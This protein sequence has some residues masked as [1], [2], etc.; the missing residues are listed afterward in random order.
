MSE[1][2][3]YLLLAG[4]FSVISLFFNRRL[5]KA[6]ASIVEATAIASLLDSIS[7]FSNLVKEE[8][9]ETRRLSERNHE[10]NERN[11]Q[12]EKKGEKDRSDFQMRENKLVEKLL[13]TEEKL[14]KLEKEHDAALEAQSKRIDELKT[15]MQDSHTKEIEALNEQ[16]R[17]EIAE[18]E[19]KYQEVVSDLQAQLT[20]ANSRIKELESAVAILKSRIDESQAEPVGG[21]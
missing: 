17:N 8:R 1:T 3:L 5:R 19:K 21:D 11:Y 18:T 7:Q 14:A 6:E 12:L 4:F 13:Q 10:M 9:E 15:Q 2:L 20:E 16:H